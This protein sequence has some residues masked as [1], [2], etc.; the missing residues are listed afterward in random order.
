MMKATLELDLAGSAAREEQATDNFENEYPDVPGDPT[1]NVPAVFN[2]IT[3]FSFLQWPA[4][5][6]LKE[7]SIN[8]TL[9]PC[10]RDVLFFF[11][12]AGND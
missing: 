3:A 6:S 1:T 10:Y 4:V 12:Y 8:M 9:N 7:T 2:A 11:S 5:P